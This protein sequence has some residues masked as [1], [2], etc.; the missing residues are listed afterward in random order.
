MHRIVRNGG[1]VYAIIALA[2]CGDTAGTTGL[3]VTVPTTPSAPTTTTPATVPEAGTFV[4]RTAVV[5]GVS[6]GYQVFIPAKYTTGTPSP[7]IM[8]I[9]G[10]GGRGNDNVSQLG[11]GGL[12][13][14]VQAQTATFPAIAIFPQVPAGEKFDRATMIRI[15]MGVL[16]NVTQTYNVDPSRI[17]LTGVSFGAVLSYDLAYLNPTRFAALVPV[18]GTIC[19]ACI[20]GNPSTPT[21]TMYAPV[22]QAL[23]GVPTWI[24]HGKNDAQ[25]AVA[26]VRNIVAAFQAAG[27]TIRYTEYPNGAHD[28][29]TWVTTYAS[30][31]LYAWLWTQHR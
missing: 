28:D 7:A 11:H 26:N 13:P 21:G 30:P 6:Y 14:V 2:A 5:G 16:D 20:T 1:I 10:G 24:F 18:A 23:R 12:G 29:A 27:G 4:K 19:D 31:D 9:H 25:F 8:F 15:V 3:G 17:Y 22:A